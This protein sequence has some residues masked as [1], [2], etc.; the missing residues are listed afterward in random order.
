MR[1]AAHWLLPASAALLGSCASKP[2]PVVIEPMYIEDRTFLARVPPFAEGLVTTVRLCVAPAG[3][4][5]S[6]EV[7]VSS[8]D[9][10]FDEFVIDYARRVQVTPGHVNG[11]RQPGCGNVR[12]EINRHR[13]T[14]VRGEGSSS[15][16]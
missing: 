2:Q 5:S 8:G 15:L 13:T 14:P 7:V 10:R 16:G 11:R 3:G 1:L 9:R 12:V 6:A 4:L